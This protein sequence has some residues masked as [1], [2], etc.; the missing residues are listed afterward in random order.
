V[1]VELDPPAPVGARGPAGRVVENLGP[2]EEPGTDVRV[3]LRH[4]EIPEAFPAAVLAA[5]DALP[6]D[7]GEADFADRRDLRELVTVT[8][9]GGQA[10]DFDDAVSVERLPGGRFRLGV[11]IAD[12]SHYVEEGS[13]LDLEAYKRGTSVYFPERAVPMLPERLSNGLCSLR[14]GV[15]RLVLSAFLVISPAGAVV[16]SE[17]A[18]SVLRS[19]RR[20][21]YLEVTRLLDEPAPGDA[22]EYGEVLDLLRDAAEVMRRLHAVRLGR[23]SID[24]DLPHG[25]VILDT[26]GYTVDVKPGQR[27]IAHR[28]IEEL[29]IAANEAVAR[30]LEGRGEP[31]LYRVHDRPSDDRLAELR[32]ILQSLGHDLPGDLSQLHPTALQE[33]LGRVEGS[34]EEPLVASLVLRTMQR[35]AYDPACNGHYALATRHY[36]H[37]TS[38]IRRYPDLLVHR[39]LRSAVLGG[40]PRRAERTL[41]AERL[42]GIALHCSRTERRAERAER[43]ILQWK[44]VRLLAGRAGERFSGRVTGVQPFGLFVQLV[45]YFVDGLVPIRT[46]ADDFY[47]YDAAAHRLVGRDRGRIFRLGD[48]VEVVLTGVD[49]RRRGLDLEIVGMPEP[50]RERRARPPRGRPGRRGG[51]TRIRR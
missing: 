11:H 31:A 51:A 17:F 32:E 12:V 18:R 20:L 13:V 45:D 36:T 35:A 34:P 37:F 33:L 19:R 49:E 26:D 30:E 39:Q 14:P 10:R 5:A 42:P 40:D 47:E 6:E 22:G 50:R 3:I 28:I 9:D 48:A 25:D 44:L 38:P 41:L 2:L 8:I 7:P 15:P 27:T 4:F 29:M 16:E 23:G 21:T 46:L 24:F 43:T 1:V